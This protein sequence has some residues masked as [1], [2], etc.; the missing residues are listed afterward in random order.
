VPAE[1][2]KAWRQRILTSDDPHQVHRSLADAFDELAW[3]EAA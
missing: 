2:L 3:S 1:R